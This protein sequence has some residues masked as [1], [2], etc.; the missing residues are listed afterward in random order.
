MADNRP[1]SISRAKARAAYVLSES[2]LSDIVKK[3]GLYSTVVACSDGRYVLCVPR[4]TGEEVIDML[5]KAIHEMGLKAT[6]AELSA[7]ERR[8]SA[9]LMTAFDEWTS[10][11]PACTSS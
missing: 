7:E 8:M 9:W 10:A 6:M 5:S 11:R 3:H 2:S 1:I 4:K